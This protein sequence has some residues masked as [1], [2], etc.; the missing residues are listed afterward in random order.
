MPAHL[1]WYGIADVIQ[2]IGATRI[3]GDGF[4][5]QI[6]LAGDRII[7]HIFQD[8]AKGVGGLVDLWF[9]G[10]GKLD[11]FGITAVLKVEDALVAP[12]MLVIADQ[13]AVGVGREG[14]LAGARKAEE[15]RDIVFVSLDWPSSA[16]SSQ[17]SSGRR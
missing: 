12:A 17:P 2:R 8:R 7:D 13:I 16:S 4:V 14:G 9:G 10:R 6:D 3:L 11:D 5:I 15:Q 1:L